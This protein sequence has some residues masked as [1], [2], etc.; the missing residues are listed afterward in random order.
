MTLSGR[1]EMTARIRGAL[2]DRLSR[3]PPRIS[4]PRDSRSGKAFPF[5]WQRGQANLKV[6]ASAKVGDAQRRIS[7]ALS[8]RRFLK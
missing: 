6:F 8:S 4:G 1:V 5:G 2:A 7:F 3:K